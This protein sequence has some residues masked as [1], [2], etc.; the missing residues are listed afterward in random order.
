MAGE[1]KLKPVIEIT[2][3][4]VDLVLFFFFK[5]KP[6]SNLQQFLCHLKFFSNRRNWRKKRKKNKP[7]LKKVRFIKLFLPGFDKEGS[8]FKYGRREKQHG[9]IANVQS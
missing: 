6:L 8:R 9:F 1:L 3:I 7:Y 5:K 4:Y 2:D